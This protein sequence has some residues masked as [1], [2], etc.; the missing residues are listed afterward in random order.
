MM[1]TL[2]TFADGSAETPPERVEISASYGLK[3]ISGSSYKMWVKIN[4]PNAANVSATLVLY[5]A[6]HNY[7]TSVGTNSSSTLISFSKVVTLSTGTYYLR[8]N[9]TVNG[10]T[11]SFEKMYSI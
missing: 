4:N 8:L 10:T 9:Y 6:S 2:P 1:V 11:H 7:I 5:N 3:H